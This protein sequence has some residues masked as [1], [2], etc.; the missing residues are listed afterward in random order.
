MN[1]LAFIIAAIMLI[2][3]L[4]FAACQSD[5][6]ENHTTLPIEGLPPATGEEAPDDIVPTPGALAYRANVHQQGVENPW[7]PIE[8]TEVVL[9]SGADA[10]NISYRDYIETLAGETRN[11]IIHVWKE[12]GLFDSRLRLYSVAVPDGIGLTDGG[13][14]VGL[15]G[16]TGAVLVIEVGPDVAPGQYAFEI[17]IELNGK[18]YG[19]IPCTIE[20]LEERIDQSQEAVRLDQAKPYLI[21][22]E[23]NLTNE[24]PSRSVGLWLITSKDASSFEEYAQTAVQA[25]LDLYSLYKRDFTSVI[26]IPRD[27]VEIAYAHANFAADGKGAAGMTGSA[28]AVEHYW[29]IWTSDRELNEQE[30]TVAEL[31]SAKQQDFPQKN[32]LSSSSYD[33]EALRQYIADTLN[34]PYAEVQ[35]PELKMREYVLDQAFI[36]WTV[37]LAASQI[38]KPSLDSGIEAKIKLEPAPGSYLSAGDELS[39]VILKDARVRVDACDRD[40]FSPWFPSPKRGESCLVVS[41]HIQNLDKEKFY[42]GMSALGYDE[43]GEIVAGTL[44]DAHI[45]GA[46]QLH[47]EYG[48]IGEFTLHLNLSDNISTIRISAANYLITP[49]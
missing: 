13:R 15:P 43:S 2:G 25:V 34:I 49:P 18:D 36:D 31:W 4:P 22:S 39:R 5:G 45:A 44:D 8:S 14:G 47:L 1:K 46:I 29:K 35:M 17:G 41:G 9:G 37:S 20:V 19:T 28:P 23:G 42:I 32:P 7:P 21:V 38:P 16:A 24:D 27:G 40:Y 10:L 30:L 33:A 12:G 3:L 6:G 48:E 11:N 26:L